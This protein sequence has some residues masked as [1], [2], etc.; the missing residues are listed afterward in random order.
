MCRCD[1][2]I[3]MNNCSISSM[4]INYLM[5][6]HHLQ[7]MPIDFPIIF[8]MIVLVLPDFLEYLLLSLCAQ[9][10]PKNA[11]LDWNKTSFIYF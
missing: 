4:S 2:L 8:L 11:E 1:K 6:F 3:L 5:I 10:M 7:Y 9:L